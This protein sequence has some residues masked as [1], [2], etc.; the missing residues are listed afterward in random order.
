[1]TLEERLGGRVSAEHR[2]AVESS[3]AHHVVTG[4]A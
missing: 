3:V 2:G 1:M 4:E